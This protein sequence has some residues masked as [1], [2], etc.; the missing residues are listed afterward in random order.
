M[1]RILLASLV[2]LLAGCSSQ[3]AEDEAKPVRFVVIAAP[4]LGAEPEGGAPPT[5][6]LLYDLV[7]ELSGDGEFDFCLVPGPLLGSLDPESREALL[8]AL[9][10]IAGRVYPALSSGDGPRQEL[11]EAL[12][13]KSEG[14]PGHEGQAAFRGKAV[15]GFRPIVV[16]PDGAEPDGEPDGEEQPEEDRAPHSIA[17]FA[18]ETRPEASHDLEVT[19]GDPASLTR[20]G[21]TI[22]VALPPLGL[23]PHLYGVVEVA[24]GVVRLTLRSAEPGAEIPPAPPPLPLKAR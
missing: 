17:V 13:D 11:L 12:G 2:L 22:R 24:G 8:G 19:S 16:G 3:T 5:E 15:R 4:A 18:A 21:E 1:T 6:D 7:T 9:G 20:V 23:P 14:L 10:Q